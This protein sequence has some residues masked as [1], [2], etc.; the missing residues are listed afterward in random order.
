MA[1]FVRDE[2]ILNRQNGT[3]M[4]LFRN[5]SGK[6]GQ[7]KANYP[8][9]NVVIT[10][11][12]AEKLM[13]E[14]FKVKEYEDRDGNLMYRIKVNAR[15]DNIPPKVFK[16]CGRKKIRLDETSIADLDRDEIVKLDM[17]ISRSSGGATYLTTGYFTIDEDEIDKLYEFDD[18]YDDD[19]EI[20]FK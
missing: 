11:E 20:P 17:T 3:K 6:D 18:D 8:N 14:G 16:V 15:F 10:Q 19:E 5:F 1:I 12:M 13:D 7:Y 9:F 2:D 4:L